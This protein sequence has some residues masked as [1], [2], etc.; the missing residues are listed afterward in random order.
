M[1]LGLGIWELLVEVCSHKLGQIYLNDSVNSEWK[2]TW[3]NG[4]KLL[5]FKF[6]IKLEEISGES[7]KNKRLDCKQTQEEEL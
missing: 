5:N 7:K 6:Q 1:S 4:N 2:D 3:N